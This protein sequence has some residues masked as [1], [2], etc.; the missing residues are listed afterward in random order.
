MKWGISISEPIL[1]LSHQGIFRNT[2]YKAGTLAPHFGS[3]DLGQQSHCYR[4]ILGCQVVHFFS[5]PFPH[6]WH[7]EVPRSGTEFALQ[8]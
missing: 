6:L 7:M 2:L 5:P 3:W 1:I 8:P 4:N